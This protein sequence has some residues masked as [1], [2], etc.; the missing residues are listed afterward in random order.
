MCATPTRAAPFSQESASRLRETAISEK[1][2]GR[3]GFVSRPIRCGPLARTRFLGCRFLSCFWTDARRSIFVKSLKP[4]QIAA[5]PA[6]GLSAL[7]GGWPADGALAYAKR[8]FSKNDQKSEIQTKPENGQKCCKVF[9]DRPFG[10][11]R[12]G[13]GF[14]LIVVQKLHP[15][16]LIRSFSLWNRAL[17]YAK[18]RFCQNVSPEGHT[19]PEQKSSIIVAN[20]SKIMPR[21]GP[22]AGNPE[23]L[24]L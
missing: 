19:F 22:Q 14:G 16:R 23:F 12:R 7:G 15:S 24:F 3:S 18:R 17:A 4:L 20:N 8:T 1:K 6:P 9:T 10:G 13:A 2:C 5:N 11:V 21:G